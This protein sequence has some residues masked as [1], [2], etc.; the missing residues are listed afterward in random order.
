[1]SALP[2]LV[3]YRI[4]EALPFLDTGKEGALQAMEQ[5]LALLVAI[6]VDPDEFSNLNARIQRRALE[7][8]ETLVGLAHYRLSDGHA[9]C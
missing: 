5:A 8:I 4:N 6:Q 7:G 1:M 2:P 3:D 9:Q